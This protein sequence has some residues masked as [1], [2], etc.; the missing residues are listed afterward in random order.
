MIIV[1]INTAMFQRAAIIVLSLVALLVSSSVSAQNLSL[2]LPDFGDPS[3]Q[4]L[5]DHK[6]RQLGAK[7]VRR[8]RDQNAVIN[9]VQLQEYLNSVGQRIASNAGDGQPYTFFW[10]DDSAINAFAMPGSFIGVNTGLLEATRNESELAGVLAHE[11]AHVAQH[12]IQRAYAEAH[13]MMLPMAAAAIASAVLAAAS[14]SNSQAGEAALMGTLAA[15]AQHQITFTRSNE[16]E[17][18]RVGFRLLSRSGYDP[19]GMASFFK[20]L[21]QHSQELPGV[22]AFLR[23]HPLPVARLADIENRLG[24]GPH[25][26]RPSSEGYFFAKVRAQ[27]LT[28]PNTTALIHHFQQLLAT[29][30]YQNEEAEHYGY[31]MALRRA[32]H[33][34]KAAAQ[35]VPLLRTDPDNLAL[36]I[37]QAEIA[38][39]AGQTGRAWALF[40]QAGKLYPDDFTLAMSY[41]RALAAQGNPKQALRLL[42]PYLPRRPRDA[43]LF[44]LYAQAA[45]RA[46]KPLL[47]HAALAEVSYINGN[48]DQAIKQAKL[49]L[50]NSGANSFERARLQARLRQWQEQKKASG[51]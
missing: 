45:Q 18:D 33:Y 11:I 2:R 31:V 30:D 6:A 41:G 4:Y 28:T 38:L 44:K 17:A 32:G 36:R 3:S 49:G 15:G 24:L 46:G 22:P 12:H 42:Q 9:D 48:I 47:T 51:S 27:V 7:A 10:V 16:Q 14:N 35:L 34:N 8:L 43:S 5:S 25:K 29:G 21:E 26:R 19:D 40:R 20:Y 13:E 37:E 1:W 23:T 50:R 39:S